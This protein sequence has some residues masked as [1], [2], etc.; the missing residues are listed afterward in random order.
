MPTQVELKRRDNWECELKAA[1]MNYESLRKNFHIYDRNLK[2]LV[3]RY[4]NWLKTHKMEP[5]VNLDIY[6]NFK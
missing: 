3:S 4:E 2:G 1:L 6:R 5:Q